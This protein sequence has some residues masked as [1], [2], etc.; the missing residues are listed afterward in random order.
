MQLLNYLIDYYIATFLAIRINQNVL[1]TLNT[2][3]LA[4]ITTFTGYY[5]N[6]ITTTHYPPLGVVVMRRCINRKE[7]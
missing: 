7:D 4:V 2:G 6:A 5:L 1:F 3:V